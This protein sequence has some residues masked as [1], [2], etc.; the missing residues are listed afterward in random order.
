M[1]SCSQGLSAFVYRACQM[2]T[3]DPHGFAL[4]LFCT[5]VNAFSLAYLRQPR[6][7]PTSLRPCLYLGPISFPVSLT[8]CSLVSW[9]SVF[10][11]E[12][13]HGIYRR[14][15]TVLEVNL[16]ASFLPVRLVRE[17]HVPPCALVRFPQTPPSSNSVLWTGWHR[18][19]AG[20]SL[21]V[22]RA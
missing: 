8:I 11:V 15:L 10:C 14:S 2:D 4:H 18:R 7:G 5:E 22:R 9:A 1:L 12:E 17:D 19:F 16:H 6:F 3:S 13:V 20:S 21:S